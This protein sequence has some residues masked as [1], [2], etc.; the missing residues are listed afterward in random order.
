MTRRCT[1]SGEPTDTGAIDRNCGAEPSNIDAAVSRYPLSTVGSGKPCEVVDEQPNNQPRL[2]RSGDAEPEDLTRAALSQAQYITNKSPRARKRR[3][4]GDAARNGGYSG[5]APDDRD[6][7]RLGSVL[8][9]LVEERGWQRPIADARVFAD[10][11]SLVGAD[12][13]AHCQP[14]NL[15]EGEL[16]VSAE[17][18]A[19]ATQLRLMAGQLLASLARELGPHTVRKVIITG[20]VG[21]SWKHGLRSVR[22]GRGPRDTYG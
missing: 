2:A 7:Q 8:G 13:A 19:W 3:R 22:D 1:V 6:P 10:W 11:A 9:G 5:A 21:P 16:R 18:T 15:H 14:A 12:I 4:S 17:S 20:P